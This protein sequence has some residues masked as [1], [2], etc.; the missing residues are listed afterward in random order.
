MLAFGGFLL[1]GGRLGDLFGPRRLFLI[2][3]ALF[4]LASLTCGFAPTRGFLIVARW[5]Q[6]LGGAV[7][8]A[9]SL[10]L[11][12]GLFT[13]P[14]E[15]AKAMG[16]FGFVCSGGGS[17]GVL[18]GGVLTGS[19][20]WHW[21]FLV[22]IPVGVAVFVL[23][24]WLLPGG[25][26][27]AKGKLDVAGA[28][29]VTAS[30]LT[31]VYAVVGGNESG[32]LSRRTLGLLGTAAALFIAF[33]VVEARAHSPLVPPNLIRIRNVAVSNVIGVLWAAAMFA[34]FFLSA[35][36]LQLVLGY[37][38]MQIGL[39]FLPAN[40][41][42]AAFSIGISAKLV[43]RFGIR[44]PL[45]V[46][47]LLAALG[48]LL[49]GQ[50]PVDGTYALHVLPCMVLLGVGGGMAFNPLLL[51]A[52][53]DVPPDESGLA[54]GI[55]NTA[56]MMGGALGLAV[57]AS[58][59]AART[60][61]LATSGASP[62]AALTGGYHAAFLVGAAFAATA[63]LLGLLLRKGSMDAAAAGHGHGM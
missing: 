31:A 14:A 58:L 45:T 19:F 5:I 48:L 50:A 56:F 10:S 21:I 62:A 8:S 30:L 60:H 2:G 20:D 26:G 61:A 24:F 51:A 41:I 59:A 42:M 17:L 9:V 1:L 46:G 54:S 57:L 47:L 25:R 16:V 40:L 23:S 13:E 43:M 44:A 6:G 39:S 27:P 11:M 33:V 28:I 35:L 52:M 22:N 32:W 36:Y 18:L 37:T 29:L 7:V 4:T 34:W 38:P 12:M 53:S 3:L 55:V 15:R 63:G 49:L